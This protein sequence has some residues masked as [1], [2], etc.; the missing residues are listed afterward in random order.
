MNN[1]YIRVQSILELDE[2]KSAQLMEI[3]DIQYSALSL[4]LGLAE[5]DSVPS[6]ME[7][8][9][10][11][12][13]IARY[14]RLGSEGLSSEAVDVINQSFITNLFEPYMS[15]IEA[16]KAMNPGA[17]GAKKLRLL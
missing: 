17:T 6:L 4:L 3:I 15:Q 10:V 14:N 12:T 5:G 8:I 16:Y 9:V 7:F 13:S 1:I 2:S 11:E